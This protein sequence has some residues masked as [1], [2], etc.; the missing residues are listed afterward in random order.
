MKSTVYYF[1]IRYFTIKHDILF[2]L[3]KYEPCSALVS[4]L[5]RYSSIMFQQ[6]YIFLI[7]Y[8][9][10]LTFVPNSFSYST[11]EQE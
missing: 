9:F 7:R 6:I 1:F 2:K 3:R 4:T 5:L 11:L 8:A 10:L